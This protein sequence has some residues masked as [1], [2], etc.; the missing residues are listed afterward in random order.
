MASSWSLASH[1][2]QC[3]GSYLADLAE[4]QP[5]K[6]HKMQK[7]INE[8]L[9]KLNKIVLKVS[10]ICLLTQQFYKHL[11]QG[12]S[13]NRTLIRTSIYKL[14][15]CFEA[16]C[17]NQFYVIF[18]EEFIILYLCHIIIYLLKIVFT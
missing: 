13:F 6:I 14:I 9:K 17:N 4:F 10:K 16:K 1:K 8:A 2:H 15:I 7:N 11:C 3:N 12:L 18:S 5:V